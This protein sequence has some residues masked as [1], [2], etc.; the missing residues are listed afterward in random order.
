MTDVSP[1][2]SP[3][4]SGANPLFLRDEELRQGIEHSLHAAQARG[5]LSRT[6]S[7]Q[8]LSRALTN[9]MIGLAVSGKLAVGRA[10]LEQIYAGTLSMLD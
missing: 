1:P 6:K 2:G 4:R 3:P 10:E 8:G 9:A 7:A 5:E